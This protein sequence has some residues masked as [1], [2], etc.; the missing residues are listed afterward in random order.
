MTTRAVLYARVS[1]DDRRNATSSLEAQLSLTREYATEQG[2]QIISELAEDDRGAKGSSLDLPKLNE[3]LDLARD[4]EFDILVTRELDRFARGLAKQLVIE[5]EFKQAGVRVEYVLGDYPD[6]PEGNLNKLIRAV[7]AEF[8]A[9]K[10]KERML[11]GRRNKVKA[12]HVMTHGAAPYGYQKESTKEGLVS[13]VIN[14]ETSQ[15]VRMIFNWYV[16]GV[17]VND[18]VRKLTAMNIPTPIDLKN[19]RGV[20]KKKRFGEWSK[21]TI[22]YMLKNETYAGRWH[23]GKK[24]S[25]T[26]CNPPD[27]WIEVEVPSIVSEEIWLATMKQRKQNKALGKRNVKHDYLIRGLGICGHCGYKL[28]AHSNKYTSSIRTTRYFYYRCPVRSYALHYSHTD[29]DLPHFKADDVDIAVWNAI[30]VFL[31]DTEKLKEGREKL[32]VEQMKKNAPLIERLEVVEE[33]IQ[34]N[35]AQLNRLLDL[36]LTGDFPEELLIERKGR[37]TSTIESLEKEQSTLAFQI[38][39]TIT[40]ENYRDFEE[41]TNQVAQGIEK[42]SGN[43]EFRRTLIE[44][45]GIQVTFAYENGEKILYVRCELGL[46]ASLVLPSNTRFACQGA[47]GRRA[48]G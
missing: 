48:R 43:F 1:K 5:R 46:D 13:L 3:A 25:S 28:Q 2:W 30:Q 8:E 6:T 41:F 32:H 31:T 14:E 9:E 24:S 36:F 12:G 42:A 22:Q 15:V 47:A 4:G 29:C 7:I 19:K 27:Y 34:E 16:D 18:I 11:R 37:L 44:K 35:Q 20:V 38:D 45:L 40:E 17:S 21:A 23:Y 26:S 33:L 10:I 39:N